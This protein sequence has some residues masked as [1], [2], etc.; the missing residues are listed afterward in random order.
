[1]DTITRREFK[2]N[3]LLFVLLCLSVIGIPS[4]IVYLIENTI[5]IKYDV[6]D[7]DAFLQHHF[8]KK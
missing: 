8:G 1:M 2:G 5:D 6:D 3:R 4:A 7:A